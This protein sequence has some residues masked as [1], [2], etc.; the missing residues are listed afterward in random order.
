MDMTEATARVKKF[1]KILVF[2]GPGIWILSIFA[3]AIPE[4]SWS[5]PAGTF[6][7]LGLIYI[8]FMLWIG[9]LIARLA[10]SKGRS[11]GA[12]FA[13]SMFFPLIAWI[14]AAVVSTDQATAISGTKK[15]PKCAELI[16]QEATLCKHCGSEV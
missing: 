9:S 11:W 8:L 13:L 14:I 1:R 7:A 4:V 3:N 16:K 2:G 10:V 6:V 15:C 5:Q 12:F